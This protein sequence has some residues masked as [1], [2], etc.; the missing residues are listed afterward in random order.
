LWVTKILKTFPISFL[1]GLQI[2]DR[3]ILLEPGLL[4]IA[5]EWAVPGL[6]VPGLSAPFAFMLHTESASPLPYAMVLLTQDIP[7][8]T[9]RPRAG[10]VH[11]KEHSEEGRY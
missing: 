3:I 4:P 10:T 6:A 5:V 8:S 9:M 2:I 11:W 1:G 7:D